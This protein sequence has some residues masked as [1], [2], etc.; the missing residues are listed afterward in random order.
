MNNKLILVRGVSG[1]GKSTIA[2]M[3]A[4]D[5]RTYAVAADDFFT[6]YG[7]SYD[8]D[9]SLLGDAHSWCQREVKGMLEDG[10]DVVVHNTFTTEKEMEPYIKM[11]EE[12]GCKWYSII[13]ENRHG[14]KSIHDVPDAT[15][16]KQEARLRQNIKLV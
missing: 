4:G 2:E 7:G 14:N 16:K 10:Y 9:P 3:L 6:S 11:A 5:H 13:V 15:I 12:I 1:A 8:F